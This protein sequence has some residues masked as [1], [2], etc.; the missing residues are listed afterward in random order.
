VCPPNA[1]IGILLWMC[2]T[3][4]NASAHRDFGRPASC[5]MACAALVSTP[6]VRS[7]TPFDS[8]PGCIGLTCAAES[9]LFHRCPAFRPCLCCNTHVTCVKTGAFLWQVRNFHALCTALSQCNYCF[10]R[11][12]SQLAML[13]A[14]F[15]VA[16]IT[17]FAR[18]PT[19]SL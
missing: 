1:F 11:R 7:A 14:P 12:M 6:M 15:A 8:T 10:D 9:H 3:V 19:N 18:P 5:S 17:T 16:P 13:L 2:I 4:A